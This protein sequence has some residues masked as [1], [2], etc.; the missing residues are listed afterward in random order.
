M[1]ISELPGAGQGKGEGKGE[2]EGARGEAKPNL[3]DKY[4]MYLT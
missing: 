3:E 1:C 4:T 2:G